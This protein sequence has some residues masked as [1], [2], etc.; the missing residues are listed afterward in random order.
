MIV[1]YGHQNKEECYSPAFTNSVWQNRAKQ[2]CLYPHRYMFVIHTYQLLCIPRL[3]YCVCLGPAEWSTS[4]AAVHRNHTFNHDPVRHDIR[5][6]LFLSLPVGRGGWSGCRNEKTK[7]KHVAGVTGRSRLWVKG[8]YKRAR[9]PA[10]N[11]LLSAKA[12]VLKRS[13]TTVREKLKGSRFFGDGKVL[14]L[15]WLESFMGCWF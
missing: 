2:I 13:E 8:N 10:D 7:A 6:Q 14:L 1:L 12:D 11:S 4:Q 15:T 5:H 3:C 9:T